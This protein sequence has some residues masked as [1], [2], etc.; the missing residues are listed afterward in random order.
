MKFTCDR[1]KFQAAFQSA[2]SVAAPRS[3]KAI[4]RNVKIEAEEDRATLLATDLD[5]S[6]RIEIPQLNVE[7]PGSALLPVDRFGSI[8]R[9][10]SDQEL[11]VEA[12]PQETLVR[13]ERSEFR[14]QA[15]DPREYP[16][17]PP[18]G[19]E[20]YHQL[21]ARLL[22]DM[23]RRTVFATDVDSTRYALGGVLWEMEGSTVVAVGT[24]GRRLAKMES[25]GEAVQEHA[26]GES[27]TIVPTRAMQLMERT[28][29]AAAGEDADCQ[30]KLSFSGNGVHLQ[31]QRVTL[32][33][34]LLE[35]R[36]PRWRDVF[37]QPEGYTH[38]S[39]NVGPFFSTVRQAAIATS[40]ESRGVE[41]A[42]DQGSL[43]LTARTA[44]W[45]QS[46]VELPIAYEGQAMK[47]ILDPRF[48]IDFLKV[49][50]LEDT[51]QFRIKDPEGAVVCATED[52]YGYVVMP[53]AP[54]QA[55][56]R[57]EDT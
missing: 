54:D 50:E 35:G 48:L 18:F 23:I 21:S 51:F 4:L 1:E 53:L 32:F 16:A 8:L 33:S 30:A 38:V 25:Q 27:A 43:V 42:F 36:F 44:D 15:E 26:T 13:G 46:K 3:P 17:V 19:E 24:D 39:L 57:P 55:R 34:R 49:L 10:S 41:F 37:P 9:E 52:G 22:R 6:I 5:I 45:G 11:S 29:A 56:R 20:K 47:V 28:A 12:S 2:A 14:L 40:T 7:V 31:V